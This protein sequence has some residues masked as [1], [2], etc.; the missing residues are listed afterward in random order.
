M[1]KTVQA[2]IG[3]AV[4]LSRRSPI[5]VDR[6]STV[7]SRGVAYLGSLTLTRVRMNFRSVKEWARS[8]RVVHHNL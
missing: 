8:R 4:Q 1:G 5:V 3:D 7:D 2:A 6:H